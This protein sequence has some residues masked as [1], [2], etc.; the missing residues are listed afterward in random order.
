MGGKGREIK[1]R[2]ERGEK[3]TLPLE[4]EKL[5]DAPRIFANFQEILDV[6]GN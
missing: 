5:K 6:Y 4:N 1:R 3:F 2:G